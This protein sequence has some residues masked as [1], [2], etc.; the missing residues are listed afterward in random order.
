MTQSVMSELMS[1]ESKRYNKLS[2]KRIY[3]K[4][5]TTHSENG[6]YRQEGIESLAENI[7]DIGLLE[8]LVV[9]DLGI[10]KYLILSG[11]RRYNAHKYLI[12]QKGLEEFEDIACRIVSFEDEDEELVAL[13]ASNAVRSFSLEDKILITKMAERHYDLLIARNKRPKG[14]KR[15]WISSMTGFSARSIQDYLSDYP[16]KLTSNVS[17]KENK[18]KKPYDITK[19]VTKLQKTVERFVQKMLAHGYDSYHIGNLE[20][21]VWGLMKEF[22]NDD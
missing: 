12:E 17:E 20:S 13:I 18:E 7:A 19:E 5:L 3:Y 1:Q 16:T 4:D 2:I 6:L 14:R 22:V 21:S 15:E 10:G 9:T 11:H 8:P